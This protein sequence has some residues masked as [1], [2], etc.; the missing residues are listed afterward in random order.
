MAEELYGMGSKLKKLRVDRKLSV[1][2]VAQRLNVERTTIYGYERD[3]RTPSIEMLSQLA[4]FYNVTTDYLLGHDNRQFI[5][6]DSLTERQKEIM[7][8]LLTEFKIQN[9]KK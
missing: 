6:V 5:C 8:I 9:M 3:I 2:T 1:M 7:N 4:L